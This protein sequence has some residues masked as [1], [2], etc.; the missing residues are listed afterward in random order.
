MEIP[1]SSR[2]VSSSSKAR[3]DTEGE[4]GVK[5]R[6]WSTTPESEETTLPVTIQPVQCLQKVPAARH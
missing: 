1:S 6:P 3:N 5:I 2:W 4:G